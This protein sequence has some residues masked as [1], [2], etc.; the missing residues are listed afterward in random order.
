MTGKNCT[1]LI[2]GITG[3]LACGK[4]EVGRSLEK[5]GFT[6]IR[7]PNELVLNQWG[8]I[9]CVLEESLVKER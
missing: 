6:V 2:L 3:G 1:S 9:V 7:F 5:M 8:E 4:S